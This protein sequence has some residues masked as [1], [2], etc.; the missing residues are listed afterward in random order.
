M[1]SRSG[2]PFP[3]AVAIKQNGSPEIKKEPQR[4]LWLL[5]FRSG[6]SDSNRR[7]LQPHCNALAGLRHAPINLH[8]SAFPAPWQAMTSTFTL[9]RFRSASDTPAIA[10]KFPPRGSER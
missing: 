2:D 5:S 10:Y 1:T 4:R 9:T 3:V 8:Y 7:P 6:R